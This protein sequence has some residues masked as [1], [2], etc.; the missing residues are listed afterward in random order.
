MRPSADITALVDAHAAARERLTAA[1]TTAAAEATQEFTGWYD[2]AAITSFAT[3]IA[4]SAETAQR[5]TAKVTDAYLAR[6][7]SQLRGRRVQPVG[8][9]PVNGLRAGITHEGA[10]GRLADNFRYL[11]SAGM[12]EAAATERVVT[13]AQVMAA[14]DTDLAF[15]AQVHRF[16]S[17][18][19]L[20]YRR[21]V[22]PEFAKD[23][24]CGLCIA[25]S[26]R[27]YHRDDLMPIHARCHCTVAPVVGEADP[28]L[29]L[30]AI[31][32]RALYDRAGDTS[33]AKLK[34]TRYTVHEH[35]ELGPTLTEQ[36]HHFRGP[37]EVAAA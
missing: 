26:D 28:G 23:G 10:Y 32:L 2:T 6:V 17:T 22:H 33:A 13:R 18:R 24:T 31:D 12:D 5:Q 11:V 34:R 35:A 30:N 21:V 9:I 14:T 19:H 25:A 20:N 36:G 1:A 27:V 29:S 15:R 4:A 3:G 16:T 7:S 37:A 8:P